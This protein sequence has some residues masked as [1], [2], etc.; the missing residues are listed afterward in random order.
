MLF[1]LLSHANQHMGVVSFTLFSGRFQKV[2]LAP[3]HRFKDSTSTDVCLLFLEQKEEKKS[4]FA[5]FHHI[6]I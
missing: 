2:S 6:S 4:N 3:S 5:P 1:D